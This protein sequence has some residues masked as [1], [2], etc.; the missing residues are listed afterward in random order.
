MIQ[1]LEQNIIAHLLTEFFIFQAAEFDKR[2]DV[3]PVFLIVFFICL[4]HSGKLVKGK[5]AL[6]KEKC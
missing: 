6:K 5:L 1:V 4:A 3:I 2:T